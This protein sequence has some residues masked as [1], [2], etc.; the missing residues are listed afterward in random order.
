[1]WWLV[2]RPDFNVN[3]WSPK[4][5]CKHSHKK[6]DVGVSSRCRERGCGCGYFESDFAC[7]VCDKKWEDHET[8][9]ETEAERV[10]DGRPVGDAYL[11]LVEAP[12]IHD[13][14]FNRDGPAN[15]GKQRPRL[16][17]GEPRRR[18]A[19]VGDSGTTDER[20]A[21]DTRSDSGAGAGSG[22]G[23]GGV[24]AGPNPHA[25]ASR[26]A[27]VAARPRD[28]TPAA[29]RPSRSA[30]V[31]KG[32]QL[33]MPSDMATD[34]AAG[35]R[36]RPGAGSSAAVRS[37]VCRADAS[38]R[39][40]QCMGSYAAVGS[41]AEPSQAPAHAAAARRGQRHRLDRPR[42]RDTGN[43]LG[44][45]AAGDMRSQFAPAPIPRE[46]RS[47]ARPRR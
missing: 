21:R 7:V 39:C 6:H 33:R 3:T 8:V 28:A 31:M 45:L 37:T 17:G 9:I 5:R 23:G 12:E 19:D 42:S 13:L 25:R 35:R 32:R 36:R 43:T 20:K 4:C 34:A 46:P 29:C 10:A 11:P 47:H 18:I 24:H 27:R 15:S 38:C 14:V 26:H 22:G 44:V 1:M 2:R 16:H 40:R 30:P 41:I